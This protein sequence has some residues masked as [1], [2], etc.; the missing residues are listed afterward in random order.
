MTHLPITGTSNAID[1]GL[2]LVAWAVI[3]MHAKRLGL[4]VV[5]T[6]YYMRKY[7]LY[8]A[9]FNAF[10]SL[11]C[12]FVFLQPSLFPAAMGWGYA[13]A[14][15][16]L[17]ISL[18]YLSRM[19]FKMSPSW[20]KYERT[21]M[22][23]WMAVNVLLTILNIMLVALKN[24][25]TFSNVNGITQFHIPGFM[26][27]ILGLVSLSAYLPGIILF[28]TAAIRERQNRTRSILLASGMLLIMI[29]GPL[30]AAA[31]T[32]QVFM[33]ADIVNVLSLGLLASGI[34][35]RSD[36]TPA[37]VSPAAPS[38]KQAV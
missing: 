11:P 37:P 36:P 29:S 22:Y 12:L 19:E 3:G 10:M 32:W 15:V 1:C 8:F 20:A 38:S 25:P 5:D 16:F 24:Q 18:S 13:I 17:I 4:Q 2:L 9:I 31:G 7:F 34:L 23:A 26:N 28:T 35:Y 33:T 30:H 14:N 27:P 21:A 6:V